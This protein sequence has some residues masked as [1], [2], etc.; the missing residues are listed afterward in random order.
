MSLY[1]PPVIK[2]QLGSLF[3]IPTE[4]PRLTIFSCN[5]AGSV[6][7][8]L[9]CSLIAIYRVI[10]CLKYSFKDRNFNVISSH[11]CHRVEIHLSGLIGMTAGPSGRAV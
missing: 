5:F 9:E 3:T 7:F 1:V 4:L 2:V 6:R 10:H 11:K 8:A